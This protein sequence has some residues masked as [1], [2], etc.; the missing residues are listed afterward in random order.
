MLFRS[1]YEG[2]VAFDTFS[3]RKQ[4]FLRQMVERDF[5]SLLTFEQETVED[6][7]T[8]LAERERRE[9][10]LASAERMAFG[11]AAGM[12]PARADSEPSDPETA[13]KMLEERHLRDY[14]EFLD[15]SVFALGGLT[16]RAAAADPE[17][18]PQLIELMKQHISGLEQRNRDQGLNLSLDW[19]LEELG[20][21]ELL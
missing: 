18:R 20:L 15:E 14:R 10:T 5:G 1:L 19:V 11:R 12:P 7:P 3:K 6:L 13:R 21:R 4:T 17:K 16:P 9:R 2:L 8:I